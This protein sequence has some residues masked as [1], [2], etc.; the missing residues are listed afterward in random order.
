MIA[1]DGST[2]CACENE[3]DKV[4]EA[5]KTQRNWMWYFSE[6]NSIQMFFSAIVNIW[7]Q[8]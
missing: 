2:L 8:E 3:E 4:G 5:W 1:I 7:D 6:E